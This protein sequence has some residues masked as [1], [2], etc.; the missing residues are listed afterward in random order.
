MGLA[1]AG[2]ALLTEQPTTAQAWLNLAAADFLKVQTYLPAD[3]ATPEGVSYGGVGLSD[4]LRASDIF[5]VVMPSV[6]M[7]AP[8][9]ASSGV[10]AFWQNA[11]YFQIYHTTPTSTWNVPSGYTYPFGYE[12]STATLFGFNDMNTWAWA[13]P[14]AMIRHLASINNNTDLQSFA[15]LL[16]QYPAANGT[17]GGWI[18]MLWY[19]PNLASTNFALSP[20]LPLFKNFNIYGEA[21][22]RSSWTD[23]LGS[24]VLYRSGSPM[25][26]QVPIYLYA[27]YSMNGSDGHVHPSAGSFAILGGGSE[28]IRTSGYLGPKFAE[29]ENTLTFDCTSNQSGCSA[30]GQMGQLGQTATALNLPTAR[31]SPAQICTLNPAKYWSELVALQTEYKTLYSVAEPIPATAPSPIANTCSLP[32]VL[33]TVGYLANFCSGA[34]YSLA[35]EIC[36]Q[37]PQVQQITQNANWSIPTSETGGVDYVIEDA[38]AA[39]DPI[40]IGMQNY[41]RQFIYLRNHNVLLSITDVSLSKSQTMNLYFHTSFVPT[42]TAPSSGLHVVNAG[43][44]NAALSMY[45]FDNTATVTP[46]SQATGG[47]VGTLQAIKVTATGTSWENVAAFA[48]APPVTVSGTTTKGNAATVSYHYNAATS[49]APA[50]Y[51][52]TLTGGNLATPLVVTLVPSTQ[53]VQIN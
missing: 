25:G 40:G 36:Q 24:V 28:L 9:G 1:A 18:E 31:L 2:A 51:Q 6:N 19:D 43:G 50:Q 17:S 30:N 5:S 53:S 34:N 41:S 47:E 12:P 27:G 20:S 13:G 21:V 15:D 46:I 48:W 14:N 38:T 45:F 35:P 22:S 23:P 44:N 29:Y 52:F 10:S 26:S 32:F 33:E 37:I 4:L 11:A 3:G 16:D 39:Y 8:V 7:L 42:V 49:T